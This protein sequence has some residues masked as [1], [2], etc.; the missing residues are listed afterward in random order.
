MA[1]LFISQAAGLVAG[2]FAAIIVFPRSI[3]ISWFEQLKCFITNNP[4]TCFSCTTSTEYTPSHPLP[5]T[6]SHS[7]AHSHPPTHPLPHTLTSSH[8][9]ICGYGVNSIQLYL[10]IEQQPSNWNILRLW[11]LV[12]TSPPVLSCM[13]F[14]LELW[15]LSSIAQL[16]FHMVTM[17][18]SAF[19]FDHGWVA[20]VLSEAR[21]LPCVSTPWTMRC[22]NY[23]RQRK[24]LPLYRVLLW[25]CLV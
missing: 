4:F 20:I 6:H 7:P 9:H 11:D 16:I 19:V 24:K 10:T 23:Y 21:Q 17:Y 18:T 22:N 14:R 13:I 3:I 5:P 8:T 2:I 1:W 25:Y 15:I 12:K